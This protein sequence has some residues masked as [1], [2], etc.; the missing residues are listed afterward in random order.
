MG[1]ANKLCYI[2]G[3]SSSGLFL[4]KI[5]LCQVFGITNEIETQNKNNDGSEPKKI[6]CKFCGHEV[7]PKSIRKHESSPKCQRLIK[8]EPVK[9]KRSHENEDSAF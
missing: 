3:S 5:R 4:L 6:P 9:R 2:Y 1:W 8:E 7:S